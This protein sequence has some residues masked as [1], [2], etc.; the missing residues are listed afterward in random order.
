MATYAIGRSGNGHVANV[1]HA[2]RVEQEDIE[3]VH[4]VGDRTAALRF[5]SKTGGWQT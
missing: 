3:P 2:K 4:Q 1:E 5:S